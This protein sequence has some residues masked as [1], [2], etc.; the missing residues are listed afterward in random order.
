MYNYKYAIKTPD[1]SVNLIYPPSF[2]DE[3]QNPLFT[4]ERTVTYHG[5]HTYT[6]R[7]VTL[8]I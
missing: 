3:E 7:D 1:N 4:G 6:V 2:G 5:G 8:D